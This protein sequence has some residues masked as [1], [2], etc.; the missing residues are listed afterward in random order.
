MAVRCYPIERLRRAWYG[1]LSDDRISKIKGDRWRVAAHRAGWC[2]PR[3]LCVCGPHFDLCT[4]REHELLHPTTP[5]IPLCTR[6][7]VNSLLL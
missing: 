6:V 3:V 2:T 5:A 4:V 1:N 7:P